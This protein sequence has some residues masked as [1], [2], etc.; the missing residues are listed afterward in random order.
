MSDTRVQLDVLEKGWKLCK[1]QDDQKNSLIS[2]LFAYINDLSSKLSEAESELRDKKDV[3]KVTRNRIE[4]CEKQIQDLHHEK[5]RHVF[6]SVVIDGDCMPF[7]DELVKQGLEGGKKTA[8][9]L[10]QAVEEKLRSSGVVTAHHLQV[11]I[12]VYANVK[13]LVKKYKEMEVLTETT[14]DEFVRGFNIG[15]VMCDYVDA[16]NGKEC[17]DEKVKATVRFNLDDVHCQQVLFGGTADNGYARLLGPIAELETVLGRVTLI[18]GPPFAQELVVIKN[19]FRSVSFENLFRDQKLPDY[20]KRRVSFHNNPPAGPSTHYASAAARAAS[21][22][23]P[24]QTTQSSS[25][26]SRIPIPTQI[27]R[28]KRGQRVDSQLFY[29]LQDFNNLKGRKLCNMFHLLGKCHYLDTYRECQHTHGERLNATERVALSAV[30]RQSP[31][32][33]GS[34]CNDPECLSGHC[35]TRPNCALATCWFPAALHNIDSKV[36]SS[37]EVS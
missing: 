13:G 34:A 20:N 14:F 2:D 35:C 9:L 37:V 11:I 7:K 8:S 3:I 33:F 22:S 29:S 17:S 1:A 24:T 28:N 26:A 12:R 25:T 23:A 5:A 21:I 36:V 30:A 16:G 6:A 15:D 4:E 31:C 10:K 32:Q 19:K 27:L 18:E